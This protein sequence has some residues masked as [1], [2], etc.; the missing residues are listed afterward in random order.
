MKSE[1][2]PIQ[3]PSCCFDGVT[4]SFNHEDEKKG[5]ERVALVNIARGGESWKGRAIN[6]DG[7]KRGGE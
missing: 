4:W 1:A 6:L 2:F 5:R 3:L 7:E